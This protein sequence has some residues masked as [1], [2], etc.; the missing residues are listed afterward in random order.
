MTDRIHALT[1]FLDNKYR[2]DD[3]QIIISAISMIK[4]VSEVKTHVSDIDTVW[5]ESRVKSE[6][7]EKLLELLKY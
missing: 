7:R 6:L 4:G 5:A 3:V 2:E 1:V